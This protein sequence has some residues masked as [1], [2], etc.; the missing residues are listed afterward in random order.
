VAIHQPGDPALTGAAAYPRGQ[1]AAPPAMRGH[2][3]GAPG[4]PLLVGNG[5][6]VQTVL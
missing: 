5:F 1:L 3:A 6:H 2:L 4:P